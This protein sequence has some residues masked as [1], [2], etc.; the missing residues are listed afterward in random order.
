MTKTATEVVQAARDEK[1][2]S[3]HEL[4]KVLFQDFFELHGDGL[5]GDDP[6]I[7]GGLATFHGQPEPSGYRK[8]CRLVENAAKFH[9]PVFLFVDTAGAYPG[10]SA[11]ENGQG[12]A[13]A[14]NLLRIGQANTPIITIMYGE[15]GSG[16]ALALAWGDEVWMLEDSIYSVLSPEGFASILWKDAKKAAEAAEV[17]KLT[18]QDLLKKNVIEGIIEEPTDHLQVC[19]NI[20]RVLENELDKLQNLSDEELLARR[21]ERFRKF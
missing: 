16:G 9:R 7:V 17:M 3:G 10:K 8:A 1:H 6:A 5:S 4:R 21:Y 15:G 2:I 14:Q 11:E 12:E 13:I 18:P 20:E 19:K